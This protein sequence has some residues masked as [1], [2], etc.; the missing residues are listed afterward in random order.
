MKI[1]Q[2]PD[3]KAWL[4]ARRKGIGGS[5]VP[6]LMGES[7]WRSPGQ[8]WNEKVGIEDLDRDP[9]EETPIR[10]RLGTMLESVVAQMLE[11]EAGI[12]VQ[13]LSNAIVRDEFYAGLFCSPDGFVLGDDGEPV[14][15]VELKTADSSKAEEWEEGV[16]PSN[17]LLQIQ[18]NLGVTGLPCAYLGCLI[19]GTRGF[20]WIK[21]DR[22]EPTIEEARAAALA[23]WEMVVAETPPPLTGAEGDTKAVRARY[24]R[25]D[26]GKTVTLDADML[27]LAWELD[28]IKPE[29][30]RLQERDAE[31]RNQIRAALGD[32]ETG[33]L[34]D[35]SGWSY[36]TQK[37][38]E[39]I[40]K[41]SE[42]R[43][44]RRK[45]AK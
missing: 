16:V 15:L 5:D 35:G 8:L 10:L 7:P 38:A 39:Y 29:L 34:P 11:E 32:A 45:K 17:Y 27:D 41:A 23:F 20:R 44:L 18:H 40:V 2:F 30:E 22:D 14:A 9:N 21:I 37:R 25:E 6:I 36:K 24:P 19:G 28:R 42:F 3:R 26:P 43:V 4:D 12:K 33:L 13:R 1:L 31:I